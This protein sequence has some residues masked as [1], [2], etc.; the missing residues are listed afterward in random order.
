M[1]ITPRELEIMRLVAAGK[2]NKQIAELMGNST[3]AVRN[4]LTILFDKFRV[5]SRISLGITYIELII[6][7]GAT[8]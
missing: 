3:N 7:S 2:S 5:D 8:K 4:R 1:R 6:K